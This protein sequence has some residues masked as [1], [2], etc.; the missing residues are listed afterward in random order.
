MNGTEDSQPLPSSKII[1]LKYLLSIIKYLNKFDLSSKM[2]DLNSFGLTDREWF[3]KK[4]LKKLQQKAK[5]LIHSIK[6]S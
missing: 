6:M 3:K 4:K 2:P 1:E 5:N